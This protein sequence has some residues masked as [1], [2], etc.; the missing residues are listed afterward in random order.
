M[1]SRYACV[2]SEQ[3][4]MKHEDQRL[5][6]TRQHDLQLQESQLLQVQALCEH[7]CSLMTCSC[8]R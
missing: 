7:M 3:A 6:V 4:M 1:F 8:A 5:L 2:Q